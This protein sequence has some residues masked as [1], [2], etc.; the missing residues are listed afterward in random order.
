METR[1]LALRSIP[2][3]VAQFEDVRK[4]GKRNYPPV[5]RC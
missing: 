1:S 3:V 4:K 5:P 2:H